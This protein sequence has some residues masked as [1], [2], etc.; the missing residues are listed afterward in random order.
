MFGC[1]LLGEKHKDPHSPPL[2]HTCVCACLYKSMHI[3]AHLPVGN[4]AFETKTWLKENYSVFLWNF[5]WGRIP[6]SVISLGLVKE[7]KATL[8]L[9]V[10]R[11]L[12]FPSR[13][14]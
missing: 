10:L 4:F 1:G 2:Q 9:L 8:S 12:D 6:I 3:H 5:P 11:Y 14:H 13:N 7:Q